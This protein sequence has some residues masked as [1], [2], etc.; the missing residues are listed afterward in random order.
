MRKNAAFWWK[1]QGKRWIPDERACRI[2]RSWAGKA[3]LQRRNLEAWSKGLAQ[4]TPLYRPVK[5]RGTA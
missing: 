3:D 4:H 2:A 1:M 5:Q